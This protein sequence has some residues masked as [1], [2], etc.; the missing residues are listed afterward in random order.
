MDVYMKMSATNKDGK[1]EK[2]IKI[3]LLTFIVG[4]FACPGSE[5]DNG[6]C[7]ADFLEKPR[8]EHMCHCR[9]VHCEEY[10]VLWRRQCS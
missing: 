7:Q 1:M 4:L 9:G 3:S 6:H 8:C 5:N 2:F 10:N